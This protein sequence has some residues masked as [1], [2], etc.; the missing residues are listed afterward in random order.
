MSHTLLTEVS[1]EL[2]LRDYLERKK[3]IKI[4][5]TG[6]IST[7]KKNWYELLERIKLRKPQTGLTDPEIVKYLR[8]VIS[9]RV[10]GVNLIEINIVHSKP[11][12]AQTIADQL[13]RTYVDDTK[14]RRVRET[15][16]TKEFI[17]GQLAK[18]KEDLDRAEQG[19]Q[20]AK[21]SRLLES[22]SNEN[23]DMVNEIADT[24]AGLIGTRM[25]IRDMEE[26]ISKLQTSEDSS[27]PEVLQWKTQVEILE[28]QLVRE[29][30]VFSDSWP[31]IVKLQKE[32][33]NARQTLARAEQRAVE[34]RKIQVGPKQKQ[35]ENELTQLKVEETTL[36][37]KL[38]RY[39]QTLLQFPAEI[40]SL[41]HLIS[42]KKHAEMVYSFLLQ[43]KNE[44]EILTATE[45]EEVGNV[46]QVLDPALLP[47][48][49][50]KPNK[51]LII[52]ASIVVGIGI[53]LTIFLITEYFDHSIHSVEEAELFFED[54]PVL[55]IIP[56]LK[57]SK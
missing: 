26:E 4:A 56:K 25:T 46:A 49:P 14:R 10:R 28:S 33:D 57:L 54:I 42:Q 8:D 24:E 22:L 50:I 29:R 48:K 32:L 18:A 17:G 15:S 5:D 9:I 21:K 1:R 47:E 27:T 13:A 7:L 31:S 6:V 23:I 51:Q 12:L 44:A 37:R 39:E 36:T 38:T 40:S 53:G 11:E 16:R 43:R 52:V 41:S 45:R 35:L 55:G 2:N 3:G 19:L 20:E 30:K 34:T